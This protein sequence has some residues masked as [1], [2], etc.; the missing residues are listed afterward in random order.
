M[1][2]KN[3]D[4][5]TLF[6][7]VA[8]IKNY[9]TGLDANMIGLSQELDITINCFQAAAR[10]LAKTEGNKTVAR[11][12]TDARDA[13]IL[14][15]Y[16]KL[17]AGNGINKYIITAHGGRVKNKKSLLIT[18]QNITKLS[19][20]TIAD[21]LREAG[22]IRPPVTKATGWGRYNGIVNKQILIPSIDTSIP[23]PLTTTPVQQELN[24]CNN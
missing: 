22:K 23:L 1:E 5:V 18:L 24:V 21:V 2:T 11:K 14:A 9:I 13:W 17:I 6:G 19:G 3:D 4:I 8:K 10:R 20:N 16:E 7:S 12:A 15:E